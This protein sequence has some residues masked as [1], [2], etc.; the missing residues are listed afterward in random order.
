MRKTVQ[1]SL[2]SNHRIIFSFL[3]VIILSLTAMSAV[4]VQ[5]D[6]EPFP[7]LPKL[8]RLD[9]PAIGYGVG[10]MRFEHLSTDEGLSDNSVLTILQDSQ[11]FLWFGT[12]EG[13]NKFDG[14]DFTVFK[15]DPNDPGSLTDDFI[16]ALVEGDDG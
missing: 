14:Y 10:T 6:P 7:R 12:Q 8:Y 5:A 1:Q 15:A 9:W 11:G 3:M 16:T 2:T 4:R 13:L